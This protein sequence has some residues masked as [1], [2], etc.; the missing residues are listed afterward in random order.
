MAEGAAILTLEE[1]SFAKARGAHIYAEI[2]GY[3]HTSDAYH[4]TAPMETG[5]GAA[6]AMIRAMIS[7]SPCR[8]MSTWEP[9]PR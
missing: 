4:V 2:L 6:M 7:P 3:G 8:L 9:V 5:E 1:L